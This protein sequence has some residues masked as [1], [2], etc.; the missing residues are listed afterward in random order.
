MCVSVD[1]F[2]LQQHW[3]NDASKQVIKMI[4][5]VP[6]NKREVSP[7]FLLHFRVQIIGKIFGYTDNVFCCLRGE[8]KG[9]ILLS[10][11]IY[12][13]DTTGCV[14]RLINRKESCIT[15]EKRYCRCSRENDERERERERER[16]YL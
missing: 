8:K 13:R 12:C 2:S 7:E 3:L 9:V 10:T 16:E 6:F 11:E 15:A 4:C 5:A 14:Y 1:N